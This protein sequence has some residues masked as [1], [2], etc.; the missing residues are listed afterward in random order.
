MLYDI[1]IN[2]VNTINKD[3]HTRLVIYING[4]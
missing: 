2:G 1:F 3:Y 4:A